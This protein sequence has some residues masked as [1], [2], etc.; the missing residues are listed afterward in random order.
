MELCSKEAFCFKDQLRQLKNPLSLCLCGLFV[1][2]Y[3][4]LSF[5]NIR[6][7]EFLEFRFAFLALVAAASYGGPIM[8]MCAGIAG[9]VI[10]FFVTPQSGPFFPGFTLTYAILGFCFGLLLY[11]NRITPVRAFLV[12]LADYILSITLTT[13][14]LHLMYGMEWEYLFTI[15][16]LKSTISL[17][18]NAI[19]IFIF[20]KAFQKVMAAAITPVRNRG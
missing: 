15:R 5:F 8:G 9:D 17:F 13:F 14:W 10:S 11:R 3:V 20:M 12:S 1:A 18:V 4:V 2:L 16:L 19:L 7:T 6:M